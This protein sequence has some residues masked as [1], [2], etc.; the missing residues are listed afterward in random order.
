[1]SDWV[2]EGAKNSKQFRQLSS[3]SSSGSC[4]G[5]CRGSRSFLY[6][7]VAVVVGGVGGQGVRAGVKSLGSTSVVEQ[8]EAAFVF[9]VVVV[10]VV[11]FAVSVAAVKFR[12]SQ[13][14]PEHYCILI[15]ENT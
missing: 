6:G 5:S 1:M 15:R 7:S 2:S 4:G 12:N 9:V 8:A 10:A 3:R 14:S 11:V 13:P